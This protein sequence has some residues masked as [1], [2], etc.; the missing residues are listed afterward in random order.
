MTH[1]AGHTTVLLSNPQPVGRSRGG[2]T[3]GGISRGQGRQRVVYQPRRSGRY[4]APAFRH[5]SA[6]YRV[7]ASRTVPATSLLLSRISQYE[8]PRLLNQ[9]PVF[10]SR[11]HRA[12]GNDTVRPRPPVF[13]GK[14]DDEQPACPSRNT[15]RDRC[16]CPEHI[17]A[18]G[19][20][21]ESSWD[22]ARWHDEVEA[23]IESTAVDH[24]FV[25][26]V[27]HIQNLLDEAETIR[28]EGF[29][30]RATPADTRSNAVD[31]RDVARVAARALPIP[32]TAGRRTSQ[33]G[34]S[35]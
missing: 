24:T 21:L 13:R 27:S 12:L 11:Q 2:L 17:S 35:R 9:H 30:R 15:L 34:Q 33:P 22:I 14:S 18:A 28:S 10:P 23:E 25:R 5:R 29:F 3:A 1:A 6:A 31:R 20:N 16:I 7:V 32:T 19:A 8:R 26:P 4:A